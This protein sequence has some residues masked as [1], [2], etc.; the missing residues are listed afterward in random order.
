[1]KVLALLILPLLMGSFPKDKAPEDEAPSPSMTMQES[2]WHE[3]KIDPRWVSRVDAAIDKYL[4]NKA[5]YKGI[6]K[7]RPHP[8]VP[9]RVIF[10]LHMRES[11]MN[12]GKHLHEGSSLRGRTRWVPKGR[13]KSNPPFTWEES[14]EDALYKLKDMENWDWSTLDSMLQNIEMFNGLGYQ[15][16]HKEVPSPYLWSGTTIYTRGKYVADGRFSKLA[17][18]K[19]LGVATVL[20]RMKERGITN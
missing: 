4:A 12:F 5:R 13:P 1:M 10:G 16:Y 6:E 8:S 18:D 15:K 2:R 3:A 11:T 17:V 9:S 14:A 20:K 19:Q 7:L